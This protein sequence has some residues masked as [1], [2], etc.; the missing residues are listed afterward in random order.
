VACGPPGL[1]GAKNYLF[2][3]NGNGT[4]T[5]VS[6]K[7][8]IRDTAATYGLGVLVADFDNDG[9]P[10][11]Y[12]ANDSSAAALYRNNRDGTFTDIATEAGVAFSPD[13]K[14]QAGMGV[15]AADY[16]GNGLLHIVKTNFEGD[17]A[18]LYRNLGKGNFEDVTLQAG[19][20]RNT[21]FLG[22]GAGFLDFDN[23]GWPDILLCNGHVYPELGQT[24]AEFGYRQRKVLY[25]NLGNGKFADVSLDGGPGILEPVPSR[26]FLYRRLEGSEPLANFS[27]KRVPFTKNRSSHPSLS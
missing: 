4:F 20:G 2:R 25:H 13:G 16:D 5:D 15:A 26:L 12:V 22:W 27:S 18:S 10:D 11:I 7:S 21:R 1:N 6:Q 24:A 9:W 14:P 17:T 23:D 3:N 19:L 8:G